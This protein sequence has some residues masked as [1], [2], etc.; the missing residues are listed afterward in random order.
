MEVNPAPPAPSAPP[1]LPAS[2]PVQ[3]AT[4]LATHTPS[5][6]PAQAAMAA[7]SEQTLVPAPPVAKASSPKTAPPSASA[8]TPT[9]TDPAR[10]IADITTADHDAPTPAPIDSEAEAKLTMEIVNLWSLQKD[11]K[12]TVRRTRAQLKVLRLELG[13]L[14]SSMKSSLVRTGRGGN[15]SAYL[16]SQKLPLSTSDKYVAEHAASLIPPEEKLLTEELQELTVD[17]VHQLAQKVLHK[18]SRLLTTQELVYEFVH[19][20]VWNIDV[21]EASYTDAGFEIPKIGS[22]D[23]PKIDAPV[24]E[25]ANPAPAVP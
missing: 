11:N 23:A 5:A 7:S 15:W 13:A 10:D 8:T 22:D 6:A 18:V 17:E 24:P 4:A 3:T 16:R 25:S 9:V 12:A 2:T 1:V 14:L 21:A 20:L 19:E